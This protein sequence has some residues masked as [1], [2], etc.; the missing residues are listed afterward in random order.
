MPRPGPRTTYKYSERFKATAVRLSQLRGVSV[1]EVADSLYIHPFMLSRWRKEAR[2][3]EIAMKGIEVEKDVAAELKELRRIKRDYERLKVEHELSKKPSSSLQN[4]R[5][6]L[7]IHRALPFSKEVSGIKRQ[8]Q[9]L[10]R[11]R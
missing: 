7:R 11:T 9:S 4:E 2:E 1:Q 8:A 5:R 3:G 6:D 10:E